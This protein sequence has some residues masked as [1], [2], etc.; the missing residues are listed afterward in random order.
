MFTSKVRRMMVAV[1]LVAV[2]GVAGAGVTG[3]H[4]HH[5]GAARLPIAG[6]LGEVVIYAPGELAEVVVI[7]PRDLPD[8]LVSVARVPFD[9]PILA[10]ATM[11]DF[12]ASAPGGDVLLERVAAGL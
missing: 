10:D 8:V 1:A 11:G 3:L 9:A 4:G 5:T 7:A 12:S 6:D 2:A